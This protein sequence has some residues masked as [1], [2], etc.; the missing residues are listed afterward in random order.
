MKYSN[1]EA[2]E[3]AFYISGALIGQRGSRAAVEFEF[4]PELHHKLAT[5]SDAALAK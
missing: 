1:N 5:Q 2:G 4:Q 3:G